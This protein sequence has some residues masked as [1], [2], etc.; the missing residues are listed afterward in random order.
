MGSL[1]E[2]EKDWRSWCFTVHGLKYQEFPKL[3]HEN[4]ESAQVDVVFS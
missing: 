1:E 2:Q 4:E 3:H